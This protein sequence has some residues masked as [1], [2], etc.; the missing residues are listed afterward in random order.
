MDVIGSP[1]VELP[2]TTA[3][4]MKRAVEPR[5]CLLS[6][7]NLTHDYTAVM[8]HFDVTPL[9]DCHQVIKSQPPRQ[10]PP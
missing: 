1:A 5:W 4:S 10:L 3:T 2:V 6:R 8:V 9:I 7:G